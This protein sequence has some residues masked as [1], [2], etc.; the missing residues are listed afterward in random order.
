[1]ADIFVSYTSSDREWAFWIAQEL[2]RLGHVPHIHEWEVES[3]Q[4]IAAWMEERHDKA[5]HTLF[6]ISRAYLAAPYSSWERTAAQW[7]AQTERPG[8]ALPV[9][10]ENCKAP[11]L[12]APFKRCDLFYLSEEQARAK[13]IDYFTEP[14]RPVSAGFP[15]VEAARN[16][17]AGSGAF[18]FPG[19]TSK[20][21]VS[22]MPL[23][24]A[25]SIF[26][27][28]A[29]RGPIRSGTTNGTCS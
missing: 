22:N 23:S 8:F 17:Q 28:L 18:S 16:V 15:T 27:A 25:M 1:L 2:V 3:G 6:V 7:A 19:L 12:L 13:L 21:L 20:S 29:P 9:F 26:D 10:I 5:D 14:K 24:R 11:T 4:N